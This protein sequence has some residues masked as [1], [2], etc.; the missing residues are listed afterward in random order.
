MQ[1]STQDFIR[2]MLLKES[3]EHSDVIRAALLPMYEQHSNCSRVNMLTVTMM[4]VAEA[5]DKSLD[6]CLEYITQNFSKV[7]S[8]VEEYGVKLPEEEVQLEQIVKAIAE[9]GEGGAPAGGEGGT[10][11]TNVSAG[12]DAATPR[13][14]R[15]K[16][17]KE[18]VDISVITR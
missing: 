10:P 2:A 13:I 1:L 15:N 17:R 3:L 8:I 11:P 18:D 14:Y 12:I 7:M 4:L 9:E 5:K 16:K 6:A